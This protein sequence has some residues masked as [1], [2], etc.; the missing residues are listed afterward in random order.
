LQ[1]ARAESRK[2]HGT[3]RVYQTLFT[4]HLESTNAAATTIRTSGIA[5]D[6]LGDFLQVTGMPADPTKVT[7]EHLVEWMRY[8]QRPKD[9][10][11]QGL[12]AQTALQR[13]RSVSRLFA[14]LVDTDEIRE[15]SMTRMKPPRVPDKLVP[16]IGDADLR[17]LMKAVDGTGFEERR[18]RAI[19]SLF[20]DTGLRISEMADMP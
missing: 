16:V 2:A 1:A 6:R 19:V 4:D 9:E 20:I 7:R 8:L 13:C 12:T 15:S 10:G 17:T 18:D 14:W 3:W 11:G 5:V